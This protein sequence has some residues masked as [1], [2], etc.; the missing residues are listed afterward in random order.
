[1]PR[2]L[3]NQVAPSVASNDPDDDSIVAWVGPDTTA[4]GTTAIY[5]RNIDPPIAAAVV[6]A[7]PVSHS[8]SVADTTVSVG[9]SGTQATFTL[10]L[11]A[12]ASYPIDVNYSTADGTAKAGVN[13][14]SA[15]GTVDFAPGQTSETIEVNVAGLSR[16]ELANKSFLLNLTN[17]TNGTLARASATATISD[18]IPAPPPAFSVSDATV[19]VGTTASQAVFMV[20]LASPA[21]QTVAVSY[22]TAD[23]TATAA[24]GAYTPTSGTLTFTP[25]QV[26]QIVSVPV[27]G[28]T[29]GGLA[30]QTFQLNLTNPVNIPISR[31]SATASILDFV[32]VAGAAPRISVADAIAGAGS[33]A[34][35]A[36]FTVSLS[37]PSASPVTM[38]Y[39]TGDG[40]ATAANGDYTPIWGTL[41]FSPGQT[42]QTV[43]VPVA[44]IAG[45]SL[46]DQTFYFAVANP[47]NG[48]IARQEAMA[49]IVDSVMPPVVPTISVSDA[50]VQVGSA[51]TQAV[52]TVNLSAPT[53]STVTMIYGTGNG[54]AT[55]A[56]GAY[57]PTG[58]TLTFSPGQTSQ[59][60]SVPV[61][62][63]TAAGLPN[64]TFF[65]A[66]A[67]PVNGTIARQLAM[68]TLV[69]SLVPTVVPTISVVDTTPVQVGSTATQA[70]F[71]VNLS[72]ATTNT[73]TMFYGTGD[74]TATAAS[75]AY[76]PTC[77]TLTFSPGQ[78]SETISVP[79]AGM[80][81]PGLP[82][83]SFFIAVANP[84]NGTIVPAT[85]HGH[86]CR[87]RDD[88]DGRS[89]N[90][91]A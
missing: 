91:P 43:A 33:T 25:G 44:A 88:N 65:I 48:T 40:T 71:T 82:N 14:S 72:A 30:N 69:D 23:G 24:G 9:A 38:I 54:T 4:A 46:P 7:P 84:V 8:V 3:G 18:I 2:R 49:T 29:A 62:G 13:Y 70:V 75:G 53:T 28:L 87:R 27:A 58:G 77:G 19:A 56:S 21:T 37:A 11:S 6:A 59:T 81:A 47:V 68:A 22:S 74:G 45:S 50:T 79:V 73:V 76:T 35:Q 10:T 57:T 66:V 42:S 67:N 85:G 39:G 64:Q 78:T 34:T 55:A 12:A 89:D 60:I 26:W 41:T 61:A 83:Q 17:P 90:L 32:P 80:N 36:L 5:L 51:G 16:S 52:F 31:A 63:V 86:A 20:S 15:S 1:M